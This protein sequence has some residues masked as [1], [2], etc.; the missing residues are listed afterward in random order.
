MS[1]LPDIDDKPWLPPRMENI[2]ILRHYTERDH[3]TVVCTRAVNLK[4][5]DD[6]TVLNHRIIDNV[7]YADVTT[8]SKRKRHNLYVITTRA[9]AAR[10]LQAW[11][12]TQ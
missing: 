8:T 11:R 9:E 6:V 1:K 3:Q 7:E 4:Y 12:A 2:H 5:L 10:L